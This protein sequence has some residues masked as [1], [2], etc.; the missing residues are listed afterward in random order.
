MRDLRFRLCV[1]GRS[2]GRQALVGYGGSSAI[3]APPL[4]FFLL[5]F[6]PF[7]F[8]RAEKKDSH[9]RPLFARNV[10]VT[11]VLKFGETHS[12]RVGFLI[13][14]PL[15]LPPNLIFANEGGRGRKE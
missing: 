8:N 14:L 9:V 1:L 3:L 12:L 2:I 10:A 13:F 4:I 6:S 5:Q 11:L 7:H 15:L